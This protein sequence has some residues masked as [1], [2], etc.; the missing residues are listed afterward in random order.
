MAFDGT[1]FENREECLLYEEESMCKFFDEQGKPVVFYE[2]D[3]TFDK[4]FVIQADSSDRVRSYYNFC[5]NHDIGIEAAE[6][7][8]PDWYV[9]HEQFGWVSRT[10]L[11]KAFET[12]NL[13]IETS[14][15]FIEMINN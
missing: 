8:E 2:D 1:T 14:K 9:Y 3:N 11:V 15:H 12:L 6:I 4:V 7:S 5:D 13:A 10:A